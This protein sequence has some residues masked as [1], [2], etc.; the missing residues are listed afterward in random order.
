MNRMY[1]MAFAKK[2][3]WFH[4]SMRFM[5]LHPPEIDRCY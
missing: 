5:S 3:I 1:A 2:P 4:I